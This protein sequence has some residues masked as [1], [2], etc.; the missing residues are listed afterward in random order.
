MIA[1]RHELRHSVALLAF[2]IVIFAHCALAVQWLWPSTNI[3]LNMTSAMVGAS[4]LS[5]PL[6]AGLAAWIATREHRRNAAYLRMG[7]ARGVLAAPALEWA[8]IVL[9]AA[10]SYVTVAVVLGVK[11]AL[12]ATAGAPNLVWLSVG[13]IA[14]VLIATVGYLCGRLFPRVWTPPTVALISYLYFA[15]NLRHAGT[16]WSYLS[17]VTMQQVSIFRPMNNLLIVGQGLWYLALIALAAGILAI[18]LKGG[19]RTAPLLTMIAALIVASVSAGVVLRQHGRILGEPEKIAY[20]CSRTTPQICIHPAFGDGL[21]RLT[22]IFVELHEKVQ[23]TPADFVRVE[24]LPR[25]VAMQPRPGAN[26]F[27]LDSLSEADMRG[28]VSEYLDGI[29]IGGFA[30]VGRQAANGSSF[31]NIE[32][33]RAWLSND[34]RQFFGDD[35]AVARLTWFTKIGEAGR[36]AWFARNYASIQACR[37]SDNVFTGEGDR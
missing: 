21:P 14:L 37:L 28:A 12:G 8:T 16:P 19:L 25:D 18:V 30:C 5:G 4:M 32:I 7:A 10:A 23:G 20:R 15:W 9:V 11:T 17:P 26:R 27:A 35:A 6:I 24:Q 22:T 29:G 3:W 36:R 34:M 2:P 33:V 13:L 31:A 1:F